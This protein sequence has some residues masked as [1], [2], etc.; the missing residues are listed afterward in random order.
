M[1]R[2]II[3]LVKSTPIGTQITSASGQFRAVGD[4]NWLTFGI[5][6]NNPE[7]P[8]IVLPGSYELRVNV[9]NNINDTSAWSNITTFTVSNNCDGPEEVTLIPPVQGCSKWKLSGFYSNDQF[10]DDVYVKYLDCLGNTDKKTAQVSGG[11]SV[12]F[13]AYT[14][15]EIFLGGQVYWETGDGQWPTQG[16]NGSLSVT[17]SNLTWNGSEWV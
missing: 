8:D 13:Y 4:T 3:N 2:I 12:S 5:V 11:A 16:P 10:D 15:V 6:L 9:T 1:S 7:T 14:P 17:N